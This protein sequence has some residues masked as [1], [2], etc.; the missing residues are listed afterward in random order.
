MPKVDSKFIEESKKY[1][2]NNSDKYY[3]F[4]GNDS[5][6]SQNSPLPPNGVKVRKSDGSYA[7]DSY[8]KN[9]EKNKSRYSFNPSQYKQQSTTNSNNFNS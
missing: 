9:K 8:Y 2:S 4:N 3:S 6:V 5:R 1:H 7:R